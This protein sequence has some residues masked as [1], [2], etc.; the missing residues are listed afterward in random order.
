MYLSFDVM[1]EIGFSKDFGCVSNAKEH[2]AIKAI[3][4]HLVVLSIG[5]HMPWLLNLASKIPGATAGYAEFFNYCEAQVNAKT[6][7][8]VL[9]KSTGNMASA[10]RVL[11]VSRIST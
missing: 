3:H 11:T 1:G 5:S 8:S 4:D 6:K 2:S 9:I 7:V 10:K